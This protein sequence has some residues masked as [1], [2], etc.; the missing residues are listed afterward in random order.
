M[1]LEFEFIVFDLSCKGVEENKGDEFDQEKT[2]IGDI[3]DYRGNRWFKTL[4]F[5]MGTPEGTGR[6][7]KCAG[8][9]PREVWAR[10]RVK[11]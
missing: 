8:V 1:F 10:N 2:S 6:E 7:R 4:G 5:I 11:I 3:I 9:G